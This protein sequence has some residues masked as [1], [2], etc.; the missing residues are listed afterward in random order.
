MSTKYSGRHH[1]PPEKPG[2]TLSTFLWTL[3]ILFFVLV[4]FGH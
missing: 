3:A 1:L 2:D 4:A